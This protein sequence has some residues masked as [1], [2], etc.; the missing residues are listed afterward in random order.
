MK[1]KKKPAKLQIL[2]Y[3]LTPFVLAVPPIL[4][5]AIGYGLDKWWGTDPYLMYTLLALGFVAGCREFYQM[6]KRFGDT[7]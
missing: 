5:G 1:N 7:L 2:T 6:I 4:G 3:M